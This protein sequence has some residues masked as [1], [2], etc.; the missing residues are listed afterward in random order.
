MLDD[1]TLRQHLQPFDQLEG[2]R[3]PQRPDERK[4]KGA[5]LKCDIVQRLVRRH[6]E[7]VQRLARRRLVH[8]RRHPAGAR[9]GIGFDRQAKLV[10]LLRLARPQRADEE[11]AIGLAGQ[12]PFLLQ[13]CQRL[14]Q[15]NFADAQLVGQRVLPDRL[16]L[17]QVAADDAFANDRENLFGQG[18]NDKAHIF[19]RAD[20]PGGACN[21]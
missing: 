15:R 19:S 10:N 9:G 1:V 12:Q 3:G 8:R 13:P 14:A 20:R 18:A 11:A 7:R 2:Q 17:G 4:V 16:L 5:V 6:V 21:S